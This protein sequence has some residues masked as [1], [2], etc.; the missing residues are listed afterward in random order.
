MLSTRGPRSARLSKAAP[1]LDLDL[2]LDLDLV[3]PGFHRV[4]AR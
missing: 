3:E 2:D 4:L 1:V